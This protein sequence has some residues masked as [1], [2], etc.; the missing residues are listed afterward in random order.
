M[1]RNTRARVAFVLAA[2][3]GGL[4][5]YGGLKWRELPQYSEKDLT[6]S[7]EINLSLDVARLGADH[8]PSPAQLDAMRKSIRAEVENEIADERQAVQNWFGAGIALLAMALAQ[9]FLQRV[10]G[11]NPAAGRPL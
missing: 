8:E 1:L 2:L 11:S 6:T 9:L 7:T 10:L 5:I 4:L 3:G